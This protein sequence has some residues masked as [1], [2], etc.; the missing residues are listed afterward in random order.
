MRYLPSIISIFGLTACLATHPASAQAVGTYF[1]TSADGNTLVLTV[2]V[3][4]GTGKKVVSSA[5]R[6][7]TAAC[8][9]GI[10]S[11]HEGI[12]FNPNATIAAKKAAYKG[13]L[14]SDSFEQFNL[15]FNTS[16][17]TVTGTVT[18]VV[19]QLAK[20]SGVPTRAYVC[21]SPKQSLTASL[22][23]S[24]VKAASAPSTVRYVP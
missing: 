7:Y 5:T 24:S 20:R 3:D 4:S 11:V 19:P 1:G 6:F 14:P 8:P 2:T 21:T 10:A 13:S 15:V 9:N 22:Q 23:T 12:G 18:S 17:N 16:D